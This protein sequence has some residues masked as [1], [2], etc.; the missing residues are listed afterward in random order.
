M[1][2][3]AYEVNSFYVDG[4]IKI[5]LRILNQ[6]TCCDPKIWTQAEMRW[7]SDLIREREKRRKQILNLHI[8]F[9]RK[10]G[11]RKSSVA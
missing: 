10:M 9:Y 11:R 6:S 7:I 3:D 4:I 1:G 8:E 5:N 2:R